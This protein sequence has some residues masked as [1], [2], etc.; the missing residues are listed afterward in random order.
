M[1]T[2]ESAELVELFMTYTA[3]PTSIGAHL[4]AASARQNTDDPLIVA[5]GT[6]IA[7]YLGGG[8]PPVVEG[9]RVSTRGFKELAAVSHLGPALATLVR[10]RELGEANGWRQD[11]ERLLSA[12]KA[13]RAANSTELWRDRIAVRAFHG[14]EA[15]IAAIVDYSC[16]LTEDILERALTRPAYLSDAT[17][18]SDYLEGP[19]TDLPVPFNR[20][21]VATFFLVGLELGHRL[22]TWFDSL[23]LPW[24]RAMV[25]IAGRQG[26]PTAG[27]SEESNSVAGVIRAASRHRLALERLLIAP[28]APVFA[29]FDGSNL[30]EVSAAEAGYRAMWSSLAAISELAGRMFDGY[31]RFRPSTNDSRHADPETRWVHEKPAIRGAED[32]FG[33]TTRLRVVME[34]PRQLLSGA[35]TDYA[36]QL[37]VDNDNDPRAITVPGLDD[38]PYPALVADRGP[39]AAAHENP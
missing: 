25:I 9:F 18:R 23:E 30:D 12:T 1:A 31:P 2:F 19:A 4:A 8:Q 6:D 10:L 3:S 33:L 27:V 15:T 28:H 17:L 7:L 26:R 39:P 24:E 21:M 14:R 11:A 34:D 5:T 32:W 20:V 36:S 29:M 38:E 13:A 22:I 37:L 35:V 16:C